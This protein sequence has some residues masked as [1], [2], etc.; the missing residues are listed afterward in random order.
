MIPT[1][2]IQITCPSCGQ[3]YSA[4]VLS[5]ID[6]GQSPQLKAA[7]LR[8]QVNTVSCPS[9][10][11]PGVVS[12]PLLYHDPKKEMLLLFVPPELNLP[13]PER[14]RL[15]GNLVNALMSVVPQEQRKGYFLNPR[16]VL[17]MQSLVEEILKAD[18]ITKEMMDQQKARTQLLQD[19]LRAVDDEAQLE[20]LVEAHK[21]EIDYTFLLTLATAAQSTAAHGQ[22]QA[23]EK[24]LKLRDILLAKTSV[25]LPEPLPLDTP[26]A[27]VID[28]VLAMP[29]Q[30]ARWAFVLYNRP[31]LDYSFFQELTS[32]IA[33]KPEEAESLRQLRT[34]LLE[35]T[36]RLDKEAQ[37]AQQA[38]IELLQEVVASPD[39]VAALRER[40]A[41]IDTLFLAILGAAVRSAQAEGASEEGQRLLAINEAVLQ[42]MQEDLPPELRLVN[43]LLAAEYPE[44]TDKLLR[45]RSSEWNAEFLDVLSA[46]AAD[47]ETPER[48]E[49]AQ[50]LRELR[51]QAEAILQS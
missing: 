32:R 42:I 14:E 40:K 11:T 36:E 24:L 51:T 50:R 12:A 13:L 23:T 45:E 37:E 5:V 4:Q 20:T 9:C 38:K 30:D 29:E 35:M 7:V 3:K 25:A 19:L 2:P 31:L 44:G 22:E 10:H 28:K 8:G 41:E 26:P 1:L 15:T 16:P 34:E 18:G 17:T 49:T 43:T 47:L 46:L 39:P 21:A 6:V 27:Q 33:A 48:R